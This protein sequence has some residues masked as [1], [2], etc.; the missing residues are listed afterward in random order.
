MG[1]LGKK[2]MYKYKPLE[3]VRINIDAVNTAFLAANQKLSSYEAKEYCELIG[4]TDSYRVYI[5]QRKASGFDGYFLRQ[6]K[7]S[8]K[9][10]AYLGSARKH[11]CVFHDKLFTIDSFSPTHRV[12]HPLICKDINTGV[13]TEMKILSEKGFREFI[14]TS[15]HLYCQD[16]VHSLKVH[17]DVMTLEVYRYPADSVLTKETYHEEYIYHIHIKHTDGKFTITR[18]FP[19]TGAEQ[20]QK[21]YWRD[22]QG[23]VSCLGDSCPHECDNSCPIWLNTMGLSMLKIKQFEKA[24]EAFSRALTIAPDFLDVQNNLGTAYGMNNQHR[25]AYEAFL[26]AHKMK[27]DYEKAL[28]GLIVSETNLGMIKDAT[29][30]CDE[31]DRLPNCNS[32]HLR[33]ALRRSIHQDSDTHEAENR[34][35]FVSIAAEFLSVGRTEGYIVSDGMPHVP[36]LVAPCTDVCLKLI[37]E[38]NEYGKEHPNARTTNLMMAWCTFA[39]IGAVYHW[40]T[41][42]AE[43]SKKGIIVTL[44]EERGVFAMDEYV[45]DLIGRGHDTPDGK[46]L[47]SHIMDMAKC[48][49]FRLATKGNLS[50]ESVLTTA[51]AMY[52]YGMVLE[53][54]ALGL[55]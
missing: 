9:K 25:E 32:Q 54:N 22:N 53:M 16:V 39:G 46:E 44:T 35:S 6:E 40:H 11:C 38:I 10:V 4:E 5:Y 23:K 47:T 26:A 28:H 30:H 27:P 31:Y 12:Y 18:E 50:F 45:M 7:A 17:N 42:W 34:E 1:L 36:E 20:A 49:V 19:K 21:T 51:K 33:E 29:I 8:P 37:E 14:G 52:L 13:Q 15:M 43:L 3:R 24:I 41:N 2:P 48:A 55:Y